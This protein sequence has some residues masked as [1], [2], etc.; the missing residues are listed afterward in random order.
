MLLT[1]S[2]EITTKIEKDVLQFRLGIYY[3]NI[4]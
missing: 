2:P 1:I 4:S 3:E